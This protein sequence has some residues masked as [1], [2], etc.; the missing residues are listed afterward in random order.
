MPTYTKQ[1]SKAL[2][3]I[4]QHINKQGY[5]Y[6]RGAKWIDCKGDTTDYCDKCGYTNR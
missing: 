1:A 6:H 5:K 2:E 4:K 3:I